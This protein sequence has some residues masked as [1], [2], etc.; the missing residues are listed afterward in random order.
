MFATTALGT[1]V[2]ELH[3]RPDR[4]NLQ[5]GAAHSHPCRQ[6]NRHDRALSSLQGAGAFGR[7]YPATYFMTI[8][9]ERFQRGSFRRPRRRLHSV[10]DR[11]P[12]PL[13]LGIA[14]LKSRRTDDARANVFQLGIKELRSLARDPILPVLIVSSFTVSI[15]TASSAMPEV[16]NRTAITIADG[17]NPGILTPHRRVLSALFRQAHLAL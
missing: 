16:L 1:A 2:V 14:L 8:S 3:E 4:R 9:R 17:S 13:G 5:H 15:Y 6:L 7:I 10:A 12:V 11:R